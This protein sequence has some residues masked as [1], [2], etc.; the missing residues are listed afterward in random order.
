[1]RLNDL[2]LKL[3]ELQEDYQYQKSPPVWVETPIGDVKMIYE[4]VDAKG[5]IFLKIER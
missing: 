2:I 4:I 3:L 1:M 5:D